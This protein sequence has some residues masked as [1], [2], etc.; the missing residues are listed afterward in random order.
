[1]CCLYMT[2]LNRVIEREPYRT[3]NKN[4]NSIYTNEKFTHK[5]V[6]RL[7]KEFIISHN[8]F[9]VKF[10]FHVLQENG[11]RNLISNTVFLKNDW[12]IFH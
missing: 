12:I 1:M 4:G 9:F 6:L 2:S 11:L 5:R 3:G 10:L 8:I 7:I